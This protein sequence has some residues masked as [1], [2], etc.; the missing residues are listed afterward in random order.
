[1]F[2]GLR[3][4]DVIQLKLDLEELGFLS[5]TNPTNLYGVHTTEG[6]K[7]FQSFY[8]LE[9]DG[10]AGQE[11]LNKIDELVSS[12]C[13]KGKR[14]KDTV[15]LKKVLDFL[16]YKAFSNPTTYYGVQTEDLVKQF[17]KKYKLP[18]SGIA[19]SPTRSK[20]KSLVEGPMFNGLRRDDVIQLKLDLE[21]LGFLSFNN[22]T[23][24]Y[25]VQT[26]EGVKEFQ[27]FYGLEVDGN[28]G[29][30]TLNKIDELVSS[31]FQKGERHKDTVQLKKDLDFLG[32]KAFSN[33]TTYYGVQTEDLVKQ[34]QEKYKL[35]VSG[36]ADSQTRSKIKSLI[37]GQIR[38]AHV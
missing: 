24:L 21:K 32:Y 11:T 5:F 1:M 9:V 18:V 6:V 22:P 14:H 8:G 12:P 17:Q 23:N 3:R 7:E 4:D 25:G 38:R 20:I 28:A 37:E 35:P 27:S 26:T 36:I 31:P 2:N 13:Q 15:Q 10:N 19:D 30:E 16:G 33:P 29:Q 34:F